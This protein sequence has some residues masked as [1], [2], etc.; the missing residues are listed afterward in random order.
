VAL[1]TTRRIQVIDS[2]TGGEPT[3]VVLAGWPDL[4]TGTLAVRRARFD[5]EH[6]ALRD[7]V[8]REPRGHDAIVGALLVPPDDPAACTGVLFFN[9][10]GTLGMCGHG[11]MG[12]IVTLRHLGRIGPGRQRVDTPVGV[13]EAELRDDGGVTVW[14]VPSF[15]HAAGVTLDVPGIGPVT[16]DVAWGGNWFF[17]AH[18][19]GRRDLHVANVERLTAEAWAVRRALADNGVTGADGAEIDHVEL[20]GPSERADARGFVLCPGGAYDRSPCGTGTS[21]ALACHHADGRLEVGRVWR[22]ESVVGSV[23]EGVIER[24][25]GD[26]VWPAITGHAYVT[27][28]ATLVLDPA[29]PLR[30]GV[31]PDPSGSHR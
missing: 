3:R 30:Y 19:T 22:Q 31:N 2:H 9:T 21:A 10:V 1:T 29:D 15:R 20:S 27:A 6:A 8:V 5:A 17:I 13:V 23:F 24:A 4:G 18:D 7:A 12:V 14:N 28:E 25:E 16:G 26:R 11:T